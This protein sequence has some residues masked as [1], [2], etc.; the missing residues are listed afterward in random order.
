MNRQDI[1]NDRRGDRSLH[2]PAFG[3]PSDRLGRRPVYIFGAVFSAAMSSRYSCCSGPKTRNSAG[4]RSSLAWLSATPPC[5]PAGKLPL[6]TVRDQSALQR[7][8]ARLQS[9][10][11]LRRALSPLIA[12]GLM[13]AYKPETWPISV[14]MGLAL[15]TIISVYYATETRQK[16]EA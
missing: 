10:V 11:D 16:S 2:D 6:R 8:V 1:L 9:C 7:R 13:T 14:Y 5:R 12:V 3:A 4:S 15:I